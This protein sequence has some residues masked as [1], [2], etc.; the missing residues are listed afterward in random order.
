MT[1]RNESTNSSAMI[2]PYCGEISSQYQKWSLT[3]S[4]QFAGLTD[5]G[6]LSDLCLIGFKLWPCLFLIAWWGGKKHSLCFFYSVNPLAPQTLQGRLNKMRPPKYCCAIRTLQIQRAQTLTENEQMHVT[7]SKLGNQQHPVNVA[8]FAI[9]AEDR[10]I[11]RRSSVCGHLSDARR[12][13]G[14]FFFF[15]SSPSSAKSLQ[16]MPDPI[17]Y[18]VCSWRKRERQD[19]EG[20]GV[21]MK[22]ISRWGNSWWPV[23]L[24][25]NKVRTS[26]REKCASEF[27]QHGQS[28]LLAWSALAYFWEFTEGRSF[29]LSDRYDFRKDSSGETDLFVSYLTLANESLWLH[30][31]NCPTGQLTHVSPATGFSEAIEGLLFD[32]EI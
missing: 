2:N 20:W 27:A 17:S 23:R 18:R 15:Q 26:F 8:V 21:G 7:S 14:W 4:D 9:R 29:C 16:T 32:G 3:S 24:I 13:Q 10:V 6:S 25:G 30:F 28:H 22:C 19:G 1:G 11:C 12:N 5:S 31:S